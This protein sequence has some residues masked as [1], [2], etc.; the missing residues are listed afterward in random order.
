MA[1]KKKSYSK[2]KYSARS[3]GRAKRRP[4]SRGRSANRSAAPRRIVI[5][6]RTQ[7]SPSVTDSGALA[8]PVAPP[9]KARF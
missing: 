8:R 9:A 3:T 6:L 4:A 2:R 1:Y 5:E 7:G